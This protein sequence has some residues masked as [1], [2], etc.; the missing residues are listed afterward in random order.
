MEK[1]AQAGYRLLLVNKASYSLI[2]SE[3]CNPVKALNYAQRLDRHDDFLRLPQQLNQ[4]KC[5]SLAVVR[6]VPALQPLQRPRGHL[7][8]VSRREHT[9]QG[10]GRG[11]FQEGDKLW[12]HF[13]GLRAKAD[14]L[15]HAEGRADGAPVLALVVELDEEVAAKHGLG[16][17]LHALVAQLLYLHGGQEAGEALVL[18]VLEGPAL[19]P[20]LGVDDVPSGVVCLCHFAVHYFQSLTSPGAGN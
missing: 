10:I 4:H 16:D 2:K 3:G 11:L 8:G 1:E 12:R 14:Q 9:L 13:G 18:Q 20:R 6:E 19:L 17:H 5:T 15:T 7:H